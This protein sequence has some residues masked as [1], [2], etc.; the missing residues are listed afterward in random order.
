VFGSNQAAVN[1]AL[2]DLLLAYSMALGVRTGALSVI[3][4]GFMSIGAYA[5]GLLTVHHIMSPGPAILVSVI[6]CGLA[7]VVLGAPLS[8]LSGLYA[9][10]ATLA[11]VTVVNELLAGLSFTGGA[12]GLAGIPLVTKDWELLVAAGFTIVAFI[13]LDHSAL[14]RRLAVIRVDPILAGSLGMSVAHT[15]TVAFALSAA[16]A[17]FAGTLYAHLYSFLTPSSF[18]FN[19]IVTVAA[20]ALLGGATHWAGPIIGVAIIDGLPDVLNISPTLRDILTGLILA[21][22]IVIAPAG[23]APAIK[24][25]GLSGLT[26]LV[27]R[28]SRRPVLRT[29]EEATP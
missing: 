29:G 19:M 28:R 8:R 13:A 16:L 5:T 7:G 17:G 3:P 15:R 25:R 12:V 1:L 22:V 23:V 21:F 27:S 9:G 2:L 4:V 14:G 6:G 10:I 26:R 24:R 18:S 20:Y 11:F